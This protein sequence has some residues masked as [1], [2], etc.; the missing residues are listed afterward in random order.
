MR[1]LAVPPKDGGPSNHDNVIFRTEAALDAYAATL[2]LDPYNLY[3][4]VHRP[5]LYMLF[6]PWRLLG[7]YCRLELDTIVQSCLDIAHAS[8]RGFSFRDLTLPDSHPAVAKYLVGC[9]ALN[10]PRSANTQRPLRRKKR[11]AT[12]DP[13][14]SSSG[15]KWALLHSQFCSETGQD[16]WKPVVPARDIMESHPGLR[17]VTL[18]QFDLL[19]YKGKVT[20]YPEAEPRVLDI[21]QS[22]YRMS[23]G[24]GACK[25]L[26]E[27]SEVYLTH[28]CRCAIGTETLQMQGCHF[29]ERHEQLSDVPEAVKHRLAGK[30]FHTWPATLAVLTSIVL[31]AKGL[32]RSKSCAADSATCNDVDSVVDLGAGSPAVVLDVVVDDN[33]SSIAVEHVP[34]NR[35]LDLPP[36]DVFDMLWRSDDEP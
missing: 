29:G 35:R 2:D 33:A 1:G 19:A 9:A 10:Q 17:D 26:T 15:C 23:S 11:T 22:V 13:A 5:R 7:D 21:S 8:A 30:A 16:W 14:D 18:R 32:S 28:L 27:N 4:D 24:D 6:A 36:G 34:E 31:L 12:G 20:N 3:W 25:T